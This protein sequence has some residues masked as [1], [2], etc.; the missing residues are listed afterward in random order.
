MQSPK[1]LMAFFT[2]T[3]NSE[4]HMEQRPRMTKAI[5]RKRNKAG[6]I[7]VHILSPKYITKV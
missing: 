6:G 7:M 3:N 4:I 2:G 1:I 5:L